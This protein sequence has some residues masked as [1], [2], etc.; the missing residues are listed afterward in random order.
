MGEGFRMDHL[1]HST[2]EQEDSVGIFSW[3]YLKIRI[4]I[5]AEEIQAI[6]GGLQLI[7]RWNYVISG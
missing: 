4:R 5:E 2:H 1:S 6:T 7:C 3:Y